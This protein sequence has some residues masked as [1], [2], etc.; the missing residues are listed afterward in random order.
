M[1]SIMEA[2]L[3]GPCSLGLVSS[4]DSEEMSETFNQRSDS[5][6]RQLDI[7]QLL[8]DGDL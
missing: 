3:H 1:E 7:R 2:R 8:I 6:I 4:K 5:I